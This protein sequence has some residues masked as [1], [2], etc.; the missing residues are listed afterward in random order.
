MIGHYF[1]IHLKIR[2]KIKGEINMAWQI[3]CSCTHVFNSDKPEKW[4]CPE[5]G[6]KPCSS[7]YEDE[8]HIVFLVILVKCHGGPIPRGPTAGHGIFLD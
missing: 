1:F 7:Y 4:T 5:C 3:T 2:G 6:G 8:T